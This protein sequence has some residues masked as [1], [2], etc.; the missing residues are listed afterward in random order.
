MLLPDVPVTGWKLTS[1]GEDYC[2]NGSPEVQVSLVEKMEEWKMRG[3]YYFFIC[4]KVTWDFDSSTPFL[5]L[6]FTHFLKNISV[7]SL[8]LLDSFLFLKRLL[9]MVQKSGDHHLRCNKTPLLKM[10]DSP[11]QLVIAWI[12]EP[13]NS[14]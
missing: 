10:V 1:E 13:S 7:I 6:K 2:K 8:L 3:A 12:S 5:C 4:S 9:L 11:Y 14:Y